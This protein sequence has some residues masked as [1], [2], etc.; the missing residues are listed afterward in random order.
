[1][2]IKKHKSREGRIILAMCDDSLIRKKFA[3]GEL[4]IDLTGEFYNG[5]NKSEDDAKK[6]I[7]EA[8]A[9]NAVGEK[10]VEFLLKL[11]LVDKKRVLKVAGVPHAE[12]AILRD[13]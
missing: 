3:E 12:V 13:E 8:N 4:L 11:G 10:C 7:H 6:I 2:L 5:E 1:M 9:I